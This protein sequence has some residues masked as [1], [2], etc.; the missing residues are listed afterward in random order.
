M[1]Q[2][3]QVKKMVKGTKKG[4]MIEIHHVDALRHY[5]E[6]TQDNLNKLAKR[7]SKQTT[8]LWNRGSPY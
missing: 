8:F 3:H 6:A 1:V 2:I 7:I 5:A 4:L